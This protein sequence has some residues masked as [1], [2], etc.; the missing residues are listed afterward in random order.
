MRRPARLFPCP[1]AILKMAAKL[2]G[3]GAEA[4][5]LCDSFVLDAA[6]AR[7]ILQW[8]PPMSVDDGL[9]QTVADFLVRRKK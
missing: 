1:P 7:E 3:R 4:A 9:Q 2:I 8:K 6:P 5:R